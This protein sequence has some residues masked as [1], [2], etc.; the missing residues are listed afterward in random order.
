VLVAVG[1]ADYPTESGVVVLDPDN[2]E[3]F[4]GEQDYT[5]VEFYAPWCGHCKSLEPEWAAAA[6]KVSKLKPKVLLAKVD[7]D[8]HKSLAEK[9]GVSGYPTIKIFKKG[10]KEQDYDGPREAK[11][12]V[13]FVKGAI[14]LTG[15]ATSVSKLKSV[16]EAKSLVS[17]HA[18]VGLF[19]EP[20]SASSMFKTFTE[21]AS[22]LSFYTDKNVQAAYS[23]S[24]AKD[25][26]AEHLGVKTVPALLLYTPGVAEPASMPIPRDRKQF[27][28]ELITEWIQKVL[29]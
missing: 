25:P 14:G 8:S 5:I 26:V 10:S 20:V 22:E 11:G 6:K 28:E 7:A 29:G 9:Y 15:S 21:V 23:S 4:I 27:T 19:R 3:Q 18:L 12:I 24:Y 13:S 17:G 2:F 16:E 1:A